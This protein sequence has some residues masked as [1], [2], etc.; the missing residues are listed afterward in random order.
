MYAPMLDMSHAIALAHTL[1]DAMLD[2]LKAMCQ[3]EGLA[4]PNIHI[5]TSFSAHM[6]AVKRLTID[7]P[8]AAGRIDEAF[9]Y[10]MTHPVVGW[11]HH[12]Y[13]DQGRFK[14]LREIPEEEKKEKQHD[15]NFCVKEYITG[16][17]DR[18]PPLQVGA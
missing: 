12:G 6:V 14:M 16:S 17:P 5:P 18:R 15:W 13:Y 4:G 7:H 1:Q 9:A 3:A 8:I 2:I 11:Y 10:A